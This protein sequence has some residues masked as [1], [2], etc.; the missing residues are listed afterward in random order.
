MTRLASSIELLQRWDLA[1]CLRCNGAVRHAGLRSLFRAVSRLG[2]GVFWYALWLALL[3]A[4]QERAV[5]PIAH[6]LIAGV[7]CSLSY[8]WLKSK[9]LRPRPFAVH[10][11]IRLAA[12]PL[13]RYS[14]PSGHT[15]HAAAF[16][17]IAVAYFPALA[18]LLVPFSLLVA[19]SRPV[20]GLHYPTDVIAGGGIGVLIA[21]LVLEIS[22]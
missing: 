21:L 22:P 11:A 17:V 1:L 5:L 19:L 12:D 9:T 13:D 2:D 18:L 7:A 3:C 16:T 4:F 6:M 15:L 8:K 20:L 14:F 10:R